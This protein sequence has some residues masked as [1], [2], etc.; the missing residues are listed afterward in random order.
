M[1]LVMVLRGVATVYGNANPLY[2]VDGVWYDDISNEVWSD[3]VC[4]LLKE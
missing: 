1:W 3:F 2:E 4:Q